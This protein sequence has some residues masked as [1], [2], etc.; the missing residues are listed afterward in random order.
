MRS[1]CRGP[2]PTGDNGRHLSFNQYANAGIP[3]IER[4]GEYCSYCGR[5]GDLHV[6]HVIPQK[7]DGTLITDWSNFLLGCVN[8]NSRK[9]C[10]NRSR[11]GYL[12]PDEDNTSGAFTYQSGGRVS[13]AEGLESD[14]L[15]G[16]KALFDLVGLG[17]PGTHTDRRRHKRRQA[18]EKAMEVRG[19]VN[20]GG[21][22]ELAVEV[23]L[24]TGF[25]SVWMAVFSDDED[26]CH[27]LKQ[28]FPG[29]R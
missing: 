22:R 19:H 13:V 3:L 10:R 8:C 4:I 16:A 25:F 23:A 24:G 18:W 28:A 14:E 20:D 12:W 21:T 5:S 26:M 29:T 17:A 7:H 15:S 11:E 27:R 1:V 9:K 2:W 6:E